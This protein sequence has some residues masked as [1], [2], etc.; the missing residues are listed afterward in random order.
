MQAS[1]VCTSGLNRCRYLTG[2]ESLSVRP[3][4]AVVPTKTVGSKL[5]RRSIPRACAQDDHHG[6][7][8]SGKTNDYQEPLFLTQAVPGDELV[9]TISA[10]GH[11]ACKVVVASGLVAGCC[12]L[13][14]A[15]PIASAALGRALVCALLLASGKKDRETVNVEFR[16][17]G[18]LKTVVA[19]ANGLG[20]VRGYVGDPKV[21]LPPSADGK[22]D[23]GRAVGSG[24]LAV[25][26]NH[27]FWKQPYTGLVPIKTGEVAEDVAQYLIDSEQTPSALGAGVFVNR[28]GGID[29]AGGFLVEMLPGCEE[30]S[31]EIV[32][33]NLKNLDKTPSQLLQAGY[34][35][36]DIVEQLMK[37]LKPMQLT[38]GVPRYACSC[39]MDSL[40]RTVA[41]IELKEL[42]E[43]LEKEGQIEAICE[44]CGRM[45]YLTGDEALEAHANA[46]SGSA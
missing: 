42:E 41:L 28:S 32:E 27:P 20:E 14:K 31:I 18:P 37:D 15:S 45:Y 4:R 34:S 30:E 38:N 2:S 11:V 24:I 22:L 8:R 16:G 46:R 19:V 25:V 23:V 29:V 43:L 33:R 10:N 6:E 9:R 26:R 1:F 36:A 7:K 5:R 13:S 39:G 44:F 12:S 21:V 40:Y 3:H 35:G 17:N